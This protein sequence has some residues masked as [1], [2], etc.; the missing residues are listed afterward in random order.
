MAGFAL[1]VHAILHSTLIHVTD[2]TTAW[3]CTL[4]RELGKKIQFV[5]SLSQRKPLMIQSFLLMCD[6]YKWLLAIFRP[7]AFL[8]AF[9]SIGIQK[10]HMLIYSRSILFHYSP[11]EKT[12]HLWKKLLRIECRSFT[13]SIN[14]N[15]F[16][17]LFFIFFF[18]ISFSLT[19]VN[20]MYTFCINWILLLLF[21]RKVK[22]IFILM[23]DD[24]SLTVVYVDF[25]S[26]PQSKVFCCSVFFYVVIYF[27]NSYST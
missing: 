4:F 10:L 16:P 2:A 8:C 12:N 26:D 19:H 3:R 1:D 27:Q 13:R 9:Q 5:Y 6:K 25:V 14:A 24:F 21:L 15:W 17:I 18:S 22:V 20:K 23:F 11:K 7:F